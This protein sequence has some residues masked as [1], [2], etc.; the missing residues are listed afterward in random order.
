MKKTMIVCFC[1]VLVLAAGITALATVAPGGAAIQEA[2]GAAA[3]APDETAEPASNA[4]QP[5]PGSG[6]EQIDE[7]DITQDL[8][9][10]RML[11]AI[12]YYDTVTIDFETHFVNPDV[13]NEIHIDANLEAGTSYE[14]YKNPD[15]G[16]SYETIADGTA[17]YEYDL[18]ARTKRTVSPVT[19]RVPLEEVY[20]VGTERHFVDEEGY[21]H[22]LYRQNP[23]N[24]Y[25]AN[26]TI[27][28]QELTFGLL[29]DFSQW[30]IAGEVAYLGRDCLLIQGEAS[31][32]YGGKLGLQEFSLCVDRKTGILLKMD[33][34]D[35]TGNS[36]NF[37][38]V[39][40]V[41]I[42][43]P[44]TD[45]NIN[46]RLNSSAYDGFTSQDSTAE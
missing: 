19:Q 35:E 31:P 9:F 14:S 22:Y 25:S 23:T 39:T 33:G 10:H 5:V 24:A 36:R 17:L 28:P 29:T 43:H 40:E 4:G 46:Q 8:I 41:L 45:E 26:Y 16:I 18:N 13:D 11:N 6:A 32:G 20:P 44:K 27:F 34:T 1:I 21:D 7:E 12:D 3:A 30:E 37:I 15:E 42:D 2:P 38:T